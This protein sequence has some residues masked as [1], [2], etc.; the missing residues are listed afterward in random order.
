MNT[1]FEKLIGK[2]NLK[3][4]ITNTGAKTPKTLWGKQEKA[5]T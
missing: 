3:M 4:Y 2:K 1:I 5:I